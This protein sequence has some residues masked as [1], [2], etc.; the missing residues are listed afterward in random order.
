MEAFVTKNDVPEEGEGMGLLEVAE[1]IESGREF[2]LNWKGSGNLWVTVRMTENAK[3]IRGSRWD[4]EVV[5]VNEE[6]GGGKAKVY[7]TSLRSLAGDPPLPWETS[8]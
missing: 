7:I 1:L 8:S 2:K 5:P 4:V 3:W 6:F